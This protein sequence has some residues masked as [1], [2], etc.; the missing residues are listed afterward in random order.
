MNVIGPQPIGIGGMGQA[1][2][3]GQIAAPAGAN[4]P[5]TANAP[6]LPGQVLQGRVLSSRGE[7][8]Q[9]QFGSRLINAQ[10]EVPLHPGA[11]IQV[12]VKGQLEGKLNLQLLRQEAFK[13]LTSEDLSEAFS[14]LK[15]P[16]SES[17]LQLGRNMVKNGVSLSRDNFSALQKG[18]ST[19]SN[20]TPQEFKSAAFLLQNR[21]PLTPK[22]I[23]TF[24][25]FLTQ[26][27]EMG[28]QLLTLQ[29]R[30][31]DLTNRSGS[32]EARHLAK[33]ID[34]FTLEPQQQNP[35]QMQARL[36]KLARLLGAEPGEERL[37]KNLNSALTGMA[38]AEGEG[39]ELPGL[40]EGLQ[41]NI[42][43]QRLVNTADPE[44]PQSYYLL[45]VPLK[46]GP[47]EARTL[48]LK[49]KYYRDEENAK[50]VDM[51]D[52]RLEFSCELPELGKT[53]VALTLAKGKLGLQFQARDQAAA[54]FLEKESLEWKNKLRKSGFEIAGVDF[55]V[56][57]PAEN[58]EEKEPERVDIE[59]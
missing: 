15:L 52:L 54:S 24:A 50:K 23:S 33:L 29:G 2:A 1:P 37:E 28:E 30:L 43:A 17:N 44:A 27:P 55:K 9:L 59:G 12:K 26:H 46:L 38:G 6:L 11:Q 3:A 25:A 42:A 16:S 35:A 49:I 19:F 41:Q 20:P 21:Q 4:P 22:N 53:E 34:G 10:S 36:E 14:R 18:L 5:G 47:D 58:L 8:L 45:Q 40:L 51:D 39:A 13:P 57:P 56:A 31:R 32:R 48:E 7:T